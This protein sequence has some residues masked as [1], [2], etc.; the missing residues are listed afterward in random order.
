MP[1]GTH[2]AIRKLIARAGSGLNTIAIDAEA[3]A[4]S[5]RFS[6]AETQQAI[7]ALVGK[8]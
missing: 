8:I 2:L 6:V 4:Q 1:K 7:N 3:E 5:V